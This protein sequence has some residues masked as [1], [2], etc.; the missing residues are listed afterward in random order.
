MGLSPEV[1]DAAGNKAVDFAHAPTA[2]NNARA[3]SSVPVRTATGDVIVRAPV[4]LAGK[5]TPSVAVAGQKQAQNVDPSVVEL[6]AEPSSFTWNLARR[7][8]VA[9]AQ[10]VFHFYFDQPVKRVRMFIG[11]YQQE[12]RRCRLKS[13]ESSVG[14]A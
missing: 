4:V 13:V 5:L 6:Y 12:A 10:L 9:G 11:S 3:K 7:V 1:F 8:V 2:I 14:S